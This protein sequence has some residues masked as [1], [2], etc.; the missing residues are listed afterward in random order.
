MGEVGQLINDCNTI[1][2]KVENLLDPKAFSFKTVQTNMQKNPLSNHAGEV[3]AIFAFDA[4][5]KRNLR[6]H[7]KDA[8]NRLVRIGYWPKEEMP[9]IFFM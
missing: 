7:V 5:K 3:N 6:L 1:K 2:L 8:Y 9:S 4:D